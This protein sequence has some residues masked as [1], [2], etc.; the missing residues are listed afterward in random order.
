V[1]LEVR[2]WKLRR[3]RYNNLKLE[4]FKAEEAVEV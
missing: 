3:L 4:R 2:T 1:V